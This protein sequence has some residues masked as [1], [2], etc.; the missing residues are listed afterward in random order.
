[1]SNQSHTSA[2]YGVGLS[3]KLTAATGIQR[4]DLVLATPNGQAYS[5]RSTDLA[6]ISSPGPV[7][8]PF[9]LNYTGDFGSLN[10][11]RWGMIKARSGQHLYALRPDTNGGGVIV[12]K[13]SFVG[14]ILAEYKVLPST[15]MPAYN[16][17]LV[18]LANNN[19]V[20][21]YSKPD[22]MNAVSYMVLTENLTLVQS[23][24]DIATPGDT[25]RFFE[26]TSL[27]DGGFMLVWY[28]APNLRVAVVDNSGNLVTVASTIGNL[29]DGGENTTYDVRISIRELSNK[30][31]VVVVR[32]TGYYWGVFYSILN[33]L[34]GL[35]SA[36]MIP[37]VSGAGDDNLD[38]PR[39]SVLPGYFC[40]AYNPAGP[41][42]RFKVFNN[43]GALQGSEQ[44]APEVDGGS[45]T[46]TYRR[47]TQDGTQFV[48][49]CPAVNERCFVIMKISVAGNSLVTLYTAAGAQN[50]ALD[51][52]CE[53][54]RLVVT[55]RI[56][57]SNSGL[58]Y[59][60]FDLATGGAL[61]N[62]EWLDF[63][64]SI[65]E[66]IRLIPLVDFSFAVVY[67]RDNASVM[68]IQKYHPTTVVGVATKTV[69]AT[70][71]IVVDCGPGSLPIN[72][73]AG[74]PFVPLQVP[75]PSGIIMNSRVN[76]R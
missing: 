64:V 52:F 24:V 44:T 35:V 70:E 36:L 11:Y 74:N 27:A 12:S 30:N 58:Q 8:P 25:S 47:L 5:A 34:G 15:G 37:V 13:L 45:S 14:E 28:E 57:D 19:I 68:A 69:N 42:T 6:A 43:T 50:G 7:R 61:V 29:S 55:H 41:A 33:K 59:S 20:V 1:M 21:A 71:E 9:L 73:L 53:Y 32:S 48:Y 16:P 18:Q 67:G 22:G 62:M 76:L 66:Q 72:T 4:N 65:E 40:L 63:D 17:Q 46:F 23:V 60:V 3:A 31:V 10:G 75:N 39:I 51:A 38:A 26:I 49:V 54:G 2:Q 56:S